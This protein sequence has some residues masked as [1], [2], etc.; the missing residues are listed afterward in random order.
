MRPLDTFHLGLLTCVTSGEPSLVLRALT[1]DYCL[2][3]PGEGTTQEKEGNIA[4]QRQ[5]DEKTKV[6]NNPDRWIAPLVAP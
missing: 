5:E 1:S 2:L 4:R 6:D 3:C